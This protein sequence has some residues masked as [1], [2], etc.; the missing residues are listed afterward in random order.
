MRCIEILDDNSE[1][2]KKEMIN[3]NMRCIEIEI[4]T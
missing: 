4:I 2:Y 1:I 3:T